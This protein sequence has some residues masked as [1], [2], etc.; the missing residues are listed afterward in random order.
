VVA[1]LH[2]E[3]GTEYVEVPVVARERNPAPGIDNGPGQEN[4]LRTFGAETRIS[5]RSAVP[6]P[7]G[8]E[9][10]G[11][12][13]FSKPGYVRVIHVVEVRQSHP[14]VEPFA[15]LLPGRLD[16]VESVPRGPVPDG[17]NVQVKL[18]VVQLQEEIAQLVDR[19]HRAAILVRVVAVRGGQGSGMV[20][21]YAVH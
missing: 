9:I 17:V 15:D 20:A 12:I 14:R 13:E 16:S 6:V 1:D 7:P 8:G 2:A 19:E 21:E 3:E 11:H 5:G 18:F 10:G 4:F